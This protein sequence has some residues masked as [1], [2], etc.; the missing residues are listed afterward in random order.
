[1]PYT[2]RYSPYVDL[3]LLEFAL[4]TRQHL[5]KETTGTLALRIMK[6]QLQEHKYW[7]KWVHNDRIKD[8]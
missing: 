8:L 7:G 4:F 6:P 5:V 2:W 1:M 3:F